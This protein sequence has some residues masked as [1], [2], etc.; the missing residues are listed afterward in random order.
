MKPLSVCLKG[1]QV[2]QATMKTSKT[3]SPEIKTYDVDSE[4][5][6]NY[7]EGID[8]DEDRF[9]SD[10]E[11]VK[12]YPS[13][14]TPTTLRFGDESVALESYLNEHAKMLAKVKSSK[15]A[16]LPA[17]GTSGCARMTER[18]KPAR[19]PKTLLFLDGTSKK[20][21]QHLNTPNLD[22]LD[23]VDE[24]FSSQVC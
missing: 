16:I 12:P 23:L 19:K 2:K 11:A 21:T 22:G 14:N 4:D 1:Q 13:H 20:D 15:P 8:A 10:D 5:V 3:Q 6:N 9:Y 17:L 7:D 24:E 18:P